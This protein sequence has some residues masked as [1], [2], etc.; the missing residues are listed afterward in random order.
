M[1]MKGIFFLISTLF[2]TFA[3]S[4]YAQ[5]KT[6]IDSIMTTKAGGKV[7]IH[8]DTE[9]ANLIGKINTSNTPIK[10]EKKNKKGFRI[11]VFS[12]S[13]QK[14]A[15]TE[16]YN[17]ESRLRNRLPQYATYVTYNSPFWKL[18]VGDFAEYA[19]AQEALNKIKNS[20]PEYGSELYIVSDTVRITE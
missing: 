15:K 3:V 13:Q 7:T 1:N 2:F 14:T 6:M 4:S 11:Q 5:N 10:G 19:D 16:V 18:R 20:F 9:I 12:G 17:R 8:Q